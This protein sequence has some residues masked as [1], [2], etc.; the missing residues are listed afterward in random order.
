M[1]FLDRRRQLETDL[2]IV[3]ALID[4]LEEHQNHNFPVKF[5][6]FSPRYLNPRIQRRVALPMNHSLGLASYYWCIRKTLEKALDKGRISVDDLT[7]GAPQ[8]LDEIAA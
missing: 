7:V 6:P 5:C 3:N 1:D 2:Q 8:Y 4:D